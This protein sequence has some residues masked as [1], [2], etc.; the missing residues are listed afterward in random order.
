MKSYLAAAGIA[1]GRYLNSSIDTKVEY[2]TEFSI[3]AITNVIAKGIDAFGAASDESGEVTAKTAATPAALESY[4][5]LVLS[6]GEAVKVNGDAA[7]SYSF[8]F[9]R[10]G[11]GMFA[12]VSASSTSIT[13]KETFGTESIAATTFCYQMVESID[14]IKATTGF[15][16]AKIQAAALLEAK[17]KDYEVLKQFSAL[18]VELVTQLGVG[19][20]IFAEYV[21]LDSNYQGVIERAQ[22]RLDDEHFG[23]QYPQ[24]ILTTE[25]NPSATSP[26]RNY[27]SINS[28]LKHERRIMDKERL[29]LIRFY[30]KENDCVRNPQLEKS[31]AKAECKLVK[32]LSRKDGNGGDMSFPLFAHR[33]KIM[34][35]STTSNS[36]KKR[37]ELGE[38]LE[39]KAV[40][41][42]Q[43]EADYS[44][45][46]YL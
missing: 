30:K 3:D 14:D 32:Y 46:N 7:G 29:E 12:F 43:I 36:E 1:D 31:L 17:N 8:S 45:S 10:L 33:K 20:I 5:D 2:T 16:V 37:D 44:D 42:A 26:D 34:P 6:I 4:K 13:D 23:A 38:A 35:G 22:R 27:K 24:R 19:N 28:A 18:Q 15:M 11:P 39:R 9:N 41:K 25:A 21:Q 40:T